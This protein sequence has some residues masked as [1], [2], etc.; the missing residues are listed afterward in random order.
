MLLGLFHA[1]QAILLFAWENYSDVVYTTQITL[2]PWSAPTLQWA[3]WHKYIYLTIT[4]LRVKRK[5]S[6][7]TNQCRKLLSQHIENH[8]QA[9]SVLLVGLYKTWNMVWSTVIER[10]GFQPLCGMN[11]TIL[12]GKTLVDMTKV[13]RDLEKLYFRKLKKTSMPKITSHEAPMRMM[14][15]SWWCLDWI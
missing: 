6:A 5:D 13:L 8:H 12:V 1:P 7:L 9:E 15:R 14:N 11:D 4:P 10:L 3:K 2:P